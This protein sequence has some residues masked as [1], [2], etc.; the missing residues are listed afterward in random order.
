MKARRLAARSLW[1]LGSVL[2]C[3]LGFVPGCH[4]PGATPESDEA[5]QA[6]DRETTAEPKPPEPP[7]TRVPI[8]ADIQE[9]DR[10]L[11]VEAVK[12]GSIGGWATGRFLP[13][14]NKLDIRT[15]DVR[16]FAV[17][18][19]RIP[20]RWKRLVILSIDGLSSE[21]RR[22]DYAV[23]HFALDGHGQW[24]VVEP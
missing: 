20:I 18:V 6:A 23:L 14:R 5:P 8:A 10:W 4:E 11:V 12:D 13:E 19:G 21:L 9:P 1:T 3:Y 2:L 24:V 15:H 22:R 16:A 17:D 7:P